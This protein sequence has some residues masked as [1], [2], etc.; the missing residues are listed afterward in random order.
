MDF[1]T[2]PDGWGEAQ[3]RDLLADALDCIRVGDALVVMKLDRL[4]RSVRHL[5]DVLQ[6]ITDKGTSL[7]IGGLGI[8]NATHTGVLIFN[9]LCDVREAR[10]SI[11]RNLGFYN[12]R[13]PHSSLAG[14]TP[15]QAY[16]NQQPPDAVAV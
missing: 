2:G 4:A 5:V 12:S 7:R 13:R 9:M 1:H 6:A 16:F 3:E 8:D 10:A 11:G 15:E 14:K